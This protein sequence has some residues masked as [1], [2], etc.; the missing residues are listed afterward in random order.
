[1][2]EAMINRIV[3]AAKYRFVYRVPAITLSYVLGLTLPPPFS[4]PNY[5]ISSRCKVPICPVATGIIL[6]HKIP[7]STSSRQ[8][9]FD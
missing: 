7:P 6:D 8:S 3:N 2:I 4:T 5:E 9:K 1:M